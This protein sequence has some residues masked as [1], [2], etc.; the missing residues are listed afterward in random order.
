MR[1]WRISSLAGGLSRVASQTACQTPHPT[2]PPNDSHDWHSRRSPRRSTLRHAHSQARTELPAP[3]FFPEAR[4]SDGL[5]FFAGASVTT[6][7]R[8]SKNTST[9]MQIVPLSLT[10]SLNAPSA[11]QGFPETQEANLLHGHVD[12]DWGSDRQ[13][14]RSVSG[15]VFM[16][17][18]AAIFYKTRFQPTVALSSTEA[19]FAAA[20]DSGKAALCPRS[21]LHELGVDQLLP[22]VTCEDNNGARLVTNAQEPTRRTRHVELKEFAA[23]QWVEDEQIIFGNIGTAT[24]MSDSLTKQTGRVKFCQHHDTSMGRLRPACARHPLPRQPFMSKIAISSACDCF[25]I[26]DHSNFD[27]DT[28]TSIG[29]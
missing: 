12:S 13:H 3:S 16:L 10:G 25:D 1:D 22:T 28:V 27:L 2:R 26:L 23:L 9:T 4:T 14:R 17:A 20:A 8:F 18:G 15:A 24:N 7:S 19:K 11:P 21:M 29:R 5:T 6:G